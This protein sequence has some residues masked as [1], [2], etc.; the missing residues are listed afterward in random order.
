M[1][2]N[3]TIWIQQPKSSTEKEDQKGYYT[4]RSYMIDVMKLDETYVNKVF[5]F[6]KESIMDYTMIN[7]NEQVSS[8][9]K[10][11]ISLCK[12]ELNISKSGTLIKDNDINTYFSVDEYVDG[13]IMYMCLQ[14]EEDS[15]LDRYN[16]KYDFDKFPI[17]D[18]IKDVKGVKEKKHINFFD[19]LSN[20]NKNYY[21]DKKE[22]SKNVEFKIY[23]CLYNYVKSKN[24]YY[25]LICKWNNEKIPVKFDINLDNPAYSYIDNK[26]NNSDGVI[27][28]IKN[29]G[30]SSRSTMKGT[31]LIHLNF[32]SWTIE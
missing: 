28:I 1:S 17:K 18:L 20:K 12:N 27:K 6:Y 32:G 24:K 29:I 22:E 7:S 9:R 19:K 5:D 8:Y 13:I 4:T 10:K 11:V 3:N 25:I 15:R 23:D 16:V 21:N 14:Y 2:M 30:V 26:I 31:P